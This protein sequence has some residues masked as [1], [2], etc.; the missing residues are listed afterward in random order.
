MGILCPGIIIEDASVTDLLL[1]IMLFK[2]LW[3]LPITEPINDEGL[4]SFVAAIQL[5]DDDESTGDDLLT[6]LSF[7][8]DWLQDSAV[9]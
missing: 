7:A 5:A 1:Y 9:Q 8:V 4:K 3:V 2:L 6:R